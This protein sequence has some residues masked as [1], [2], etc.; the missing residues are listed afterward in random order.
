MEG[1]KIE[2]L[3]Q[4]FK[5]VGLEDSDFE[6]L[7]KEDIEDFTPFVDKAK[8]G[9]KAVL[10]SDTEF[11]DNISKPF[12]DLP[13]GKEKQLKKEAR[14]Y[15]NLTIKEDD[16]S[17]MPLSEILALG[18]ANMKSSDNEEIEKYKNAYSELLE[19][20]EKYKNEILPNSLKEVESKWESKVRSKEIF[21]E[22]MG[23]VAS[24]TQVA[25][26][27]ISVVA[28]TFLGYLSQLGLKLEMD[29]K[30]TIK[31]YGQD[32]LQAKSKDGGVLHLKDAL[33]DFS[34][35]MQ[36]NVKP[37]GSPSPSNNQ[38]V[39]TSARQLLS[40]MGKGFGS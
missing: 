14:K 26:E 17:K 37:A 24:E 21:E 25:K 40:Q 7:S 33:K 22:L 19:E 15:F 27:N 23:E 34:T 39:N 38:N 4:F 36:M 18:T 28:T 8:D 31:I 30:R 29:A 32:G 5:Q 35:K 12:K 9:I 20:N 11:I 10:M 13:I 6:K 1:L 3:Q 16:L 2:N